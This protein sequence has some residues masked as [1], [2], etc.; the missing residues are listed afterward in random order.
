MAL[1]FY[2]DAALKLP[3]NAISPKRFLFQ[4]KGGLK[5]SSLWIADVYSSKATIQAGTNSATRI[6]SSGGTSVL[7]FLI[8]LG[9][10]VGGTTYAFSV[11]VKNQG[12]T[13]VTILG[14]AGASLGSSGTIA[15][16]QTSQV[17]GT[18]FETGNNCG[19]G[20]PCQ[21]QMQFNVANAGD[22]MDVVAANP[23]VTANG[24]PNLITGAALTFGSPFG[25]FSGS[26]ITLTQNQFLVPNTISLTDTSGFFDSTAIAAM[27]GGVATG[28][29]GTNTFTY[30]GKSQS[31][32]TGV[33]GITAII[34]VGDTVAPKIIYKGIGGAN[35]EVFPA[36]SDL[37]NFGIKVA[38]GTTM[39]L[40]FPGLPAIYG[41]N[42]IQSGAAN[43]I[44][45]F[46]SVQMPAGADQEFTL[47]SLQVNNLYRRDAGDTTAFSPTE[48]AFAPV[49]NLYAYR[50]D[51]SLQLPIRVL[52]LNRQ[53][54]SSTPGFVVGSY[55]WRGA[56]NRNATAIVPTH[57]DIDP[58]S[59]GLE[60]FIAGIGDQQDLQ[61]TQLIEDQ[62]SIHAMLQRG[63]YFTGANRY[64]LGAQPALEFLQCSQAAANP[65]GT[66]TLQLQGTPR[67]TAP[68]FVGTWSLDNQ[69]Y[70][71]KSLEY[72]YEA[73]LT[74]PDG[75]A[76][77]DLPARYFTFNRTTNTIT[78]NTY[79]GQTL[80]LL[81]TASGQAIDYFDIPVYPVDNVSLVYVAHASTTT[82]TYAPTWMFNREQGTI[83]V[84]SIPGALV[85]EAIYASCS[86]AVAVLYDT[87]AT[88]TQEITKVDFNPAFS[89]LAG[90]YFYLQHRRQKPTSLVL[91]CDKPQIAIPATVSSIIGLVA[92]GPV[93]FENDFAL[94]SVTAYS[95]T[96]NETIPNAKLNVVV[97]PTTFTGTINYQNPLTQTVSVI[98]GGDGTANLI[99]VP[100]SGFGIWI[101]TS[102]AGGGLGGV[103]TTNIANDTLVLPAPVPLSQIW[104][105]QESWL[106]TTYSVLNNDP[107]FGMVGA[108]TSLGQIPFQTTGTPGSPGYKTNGERDVWTTGAAGENASTGVLVTPI[109]ARDS[110]N[111]SY[112]SSSFN[113]NVTSLIYATAVPSGPFVGAYFLTFVQRVL[114][115]LQLDSSNL[116][117]NSILLQMATPTL[118]VEN[119]WLILND[120]TNGL[121]NQFRLGYVRRS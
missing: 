10:G 65:D 60:K 48:G 2:A 95:S 74:N 31:Q 30:T 53:V 13:T 50:H 117:S 38:V 103:A 56:D 116:F 9:T 64:Y 96:T 49:G 87:G 100:A 59:I 19:V 44:Q 94:L 66:V 26:S 45:V 67:S 24:G 22:A 68:L 29:S 98:T 63:E 92:F 72:V 42:Q 14:S 18:I 81:G 15:P 82:P 8:T 85:G 16:G 4:P 46:L 1:A 25:S 35:L 33:S 111:H 5:T 54:Q 90:G 93:Y 79:V 118:I 106:V 121:L 37:A 88:D 75:S 78:L 52:P 115:K 3:I 11:L 112:T 41:V 89:G 101:P 6:Q 86:P 58:S 43:A 12:L 84:P 76:R 34:N 104:N 70:Y 77:T 20:N 47:F 113:G 105:P 80:A 99:F 110:S 71:E 107:L 120:A 108:S 91:S 57:W 17:S 119:P 73:T 36:G 55:R 62:D 114:V 109:D 27:S 69:G 32:L 83:Q 39:A 102:A 28:T 23:S 97:D 40:G 61:L 7:K 21:I 51:E